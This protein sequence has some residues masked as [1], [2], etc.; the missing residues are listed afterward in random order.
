M[1]EIDRRDTIDKPYKQGS[2]KLAV[3]LSGTQAQ[4]II[5]DA[6]DP[7]WYVLGELEG[8]DFGPSRDT[9]EVTNEAGEQVVQVTNREE[10]VISN[11]IMSTDDQTL[12][13]L[14]WLEDHYVPARYPLPAGVDDTGTQLSQLWYFPFATIMKE[15]WRVNTTNETRT[16]QFTMKAVKRQGSPIYTFATVDLDAPT[17]WPTDLDDA[18]DDVFSPVV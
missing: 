10:F 18:K 11:T 12:K 4:E 16:R 15:D 7:G 2:S 6:A 5:D 13:L 8:G 9:D 3:G 17:G 1:A 14:T